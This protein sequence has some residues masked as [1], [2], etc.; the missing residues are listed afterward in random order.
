MSSGFPSLEP[1]NFGS[2]QVLIFWGFLHTLLGAFAARETNSACHH[3]LIGG[4][5][6]FPGMDSGKL[7]NFGLGRVSDFSGFLNTLVGVLAA[8]ENENKQS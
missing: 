2:G 7:G 6:G 8:R 5:Q 3:R 1:R 4:Y